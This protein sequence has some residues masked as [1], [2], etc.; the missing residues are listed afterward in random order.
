MTELAHEFA[1]RAHRLLIGG[2][3]VS[4]SGSDTIAIVDPA[5]GDAIG[6]VAAGTAADVD[7]AVSSATAALATGA[8]GGWKPADRAQALLKLADAIDAHADELA[9]LETL[10]VGKPIANTQ[11]IDIPGAAA[12]IRYFAGWAGKVGGET[13]ELSAPGTWHAYSIRQPI[14]VVGQ[15]VPWNYPLMGAATKIAPALAAGCAVVLK[16]AEQT[17]LSTL[18]LGDLAIEAGIPAGLLN[19]VTGTGPVAGAALVRHPDVAKISFTGSTV[20]G[21]TI[22]REAAAT[23][24]RVTVELGGKSPVVV[25]PDADLPSAARAIAIGIFLNSGQTCSAGSRLLVHASVADELVGLVAEM[26]HAMRVGAPAD[27]ATQIGPLVSAQHRD[28]VMGYVHS[29]RAEG[30]T[31]AAGGDAGTGMG[32]FVP[33]TVLTNVRPGMTAVDEEIFG[34]V[35]AVMPFETFDLDEIAAL[36]NATEY[37]LAAYVWTRNLAYAHGLIARLRA[38]TVRV[39]AMGGNDFA[40]PVGGFGQSGFGRENGRVGVE[41]YTELKSVT[42]SY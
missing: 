22:I 20:T 35:L 5:T 27:P 32:Y 42:L 19:I 34:P 6:A 8:R 4:P 24:K 7:A 18:R 14:G 2:E 29:A 33:P 11:R 40:M 10:D 39:N 9:W 23:I 26:A 12:A 31:V 41:A 1:R 36:A 21:R 28:R 3:W 17:S 30:A 16:P 37:G 38:G 25:M 13:M 15:I